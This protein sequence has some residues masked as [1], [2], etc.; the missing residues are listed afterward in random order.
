MIFIALIKD[1][2]I[3]NINYSFI[4]STKTII[5]TTQLVSHTSLHAVMVNVSHKMLIVMAQ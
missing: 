1:F 2:N 5:L 3:F 4:T